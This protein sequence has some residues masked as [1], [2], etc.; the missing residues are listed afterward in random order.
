VERIYVPEQVADAFL[1]A[2]VGAAGDLVPGAPGDPGATLGPL[3]DEGQ[4]ELVAAHVAEALDA[5]A[6]AL[7]GGRRLGRAGFFYEP[8]VLAQVRAGMRVVDEETFGP[9]A[10]VRWC[11]RSTRPSRPP[12]RARTGWRRR[13]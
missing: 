5:G 13:S 9:V 2:L 6:V 10:A 11:P 12:A 4:R 8:T 1:D 3:I 7:C